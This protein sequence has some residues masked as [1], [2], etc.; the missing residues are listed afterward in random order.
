M[1]QLVSKLKNVIAKGKLVVGFPTLD[2]ANAWVESIEHSHKQCRPPIAAF[3]FEWAVVV[4]PDG[5]HV[6]K[7][8]EIEQEMLSSI[9]AKRYQRGKETIE[10]VEL[11]TEAEM[12][13]M[14][15]KYG[16]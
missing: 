9:N 11:A 4:T 1:T 14:Q 5:I 6:R 16:F 12:E 3:G 7:T 10:S 8:Y 2:A 13:A 15:E